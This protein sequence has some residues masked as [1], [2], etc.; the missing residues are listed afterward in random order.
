MRLDRSNANLTYQVG[1]GMP[2]DVQ[3]YNSLSFQ[4]LGDSSKLP[5]FTCYVEFP[6]ELNCGMAVTG[7]PASMLIAGD[8]LWLGSPWTQLLP[9]VGS[10]FNRAVS[11]TADIYL[12]GTTDGRVF[13]GTDPASLSQL[14]QSPTS[15]AIAALAYSSN[16]TY[17]IAT[18]TTSGAGRLYRLTCQAPALACTAVDQSPGIPT[19]EIMSLLVAPNTIDTLLT[20]IRNAGVYRGVPNGSANTLTWTALNN[21][22]P[23]A[24]TATSLNAISSN[25][26][27]L[28]TCCLAARHLCTVPTTS[29]KPFVTGHVVRDSRGSAPIPNRP[30]GALN[31]LI[32]TA[33]IDTAPVDFFSAVNLSGSAAT[34]LRNAVGTTRRVAHH[35]QGYF[36]HCGYHNFC[37]VKHPRR[38]ALHRETACRGYS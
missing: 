32:S 38:I 6:I 34:I 25:V 3:S 24:V 4:E 14:F 15:A 2:S 37:T 12:V 18:Q 5:S 30:P 36:G 19:G 9:S 13:G 23:A 10:V 31:P 1:Q 17:F 21:G 26:V 28:S 29:G 33:V 20:A 27:F 11:K 16:S 35:L 7:G 8:G 22:L